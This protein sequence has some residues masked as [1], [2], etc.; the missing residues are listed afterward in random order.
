MKVS[1]HFL[2]PPPNFPPPLIRG[3][4][5]VGSFL[6][7]PFYLSGLRPPIAET[8]LSMLPGSYPSE[9]PVDPI[10]YRVGDKRRLH[11]LDTVPSKRTKLNRVGEKILTLPERLLTT[12]RLAARS[13]LS[14]SRRPRLSGGRPPASFDP[15]SRNDFLCGRI[16][17]LPF[18][19]RSRCSCCRVLLRMFLSPFHPLSRFSIH[20]TPF[21]S[22]RYCMT[23]YRTVVMSPAEIYHPVLYCSDVLVSVLLNIMIRI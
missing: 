17:R 14:R 11:A 2:L 4:T 12:P 21:S 22:L 6:R 19:G 10:Q 13:I 20:L 3:F 1:K 7:D 9:G 15:C 23:L 8:V 5:Q 16:S 18:G